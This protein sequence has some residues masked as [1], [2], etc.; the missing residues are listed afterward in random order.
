MIF[1]GENGYQQGESVGQLHKHQHRLFVGFGG[2]TQ[3]I[4]FQKLG[5]NAVGGGICSAKG[6]AMVIGICQ[7][8]NG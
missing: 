7:I 2:G 8:D 5:K 3:G 6:V 1:A 4:C